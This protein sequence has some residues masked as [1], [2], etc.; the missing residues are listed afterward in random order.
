MPKPIALV[1]NTNAT[2]RNRK[3]VTMVWNG[4]YI[5]HASRS[6]GTFRNLMNAGDPLSRKNYTCGGP[7][8]LS[9]LPSV[10]QNVSLYR[11][12]VKS[13][14]CDGTNIPSASCNVKYVYDSSNFTRFRKETA[15]NKS[16]NDTSFSGPGN[17]AQTALRRARI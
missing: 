13:T 4:D 10:K 3:V 8:P 14:D 7:N 17:G 1:N 2:A 16:Y 11:G 5:N 9:N 15:I 6:G 12:G